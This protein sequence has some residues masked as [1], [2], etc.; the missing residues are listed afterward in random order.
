[1]NAEDLERLVDGALKRLPGPRAPV[2]L[3]PR[4]LAATVHRAPAPWYSRPW[5]T[6][7]RACQVASIAAVAAL[8]VGLALV[9]HA[10]QQ[11]PL[12]LASAASAG[13][14]HLLAAAAESTRHAS[15]LVRVCWQ[16]LLAPVAFWV[17]V[18]TMSLSL[19]CA[20]VWAT[21]DRLSQDSGFGDRESGAMP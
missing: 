17:L 20:G 12:A 15:T 9:R 21:V 6:W 16:I 2:T 8:V 5:V 1:M 10:L 3:L 19:A 13:D 4:V 11:P 18:L 7:P 14:L